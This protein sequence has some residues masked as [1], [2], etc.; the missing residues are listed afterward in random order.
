MGQS[1]VLLVDDDEALLGALTEFLRGE[2]YLAQ[3][4]SS[5]DVALVLLQQVPYRLLITDIVLPGLLDGYALARRAREFRPSIPIIYTTG[6]MQVAHVRAHGAPFGE[7][8]VKPYR[9]ETLLMAVSSALGER[10]ESERYVNSG[11]SKPRGSHGLS[12]TPSM[13][14]DS[15]MQVPRKSGGS[16]VATA[17]NLKPEECPDFRLKV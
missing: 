17:T 10:H 7:M 16:A 13:R 2:G 12:S 3:P 15:P 4:A 8:L 14:R 1:Q 9:I 11:S 5:G 6:H